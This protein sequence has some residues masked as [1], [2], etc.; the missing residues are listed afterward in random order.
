VAGI[1][2]GL[3]VFAVERMTIDPDCGLKTRTIE[4]AEEKLRHMV[5][6]VGLVRSELGLQHSFS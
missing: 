1:K 3:E 5:A 4:E 6:A 2:K